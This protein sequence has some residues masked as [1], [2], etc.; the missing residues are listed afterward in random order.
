MKKYKQ[1]S[2]EERVTIKICLW[3]KM[4]INEIARNM[5]RSPSTISR[6]IKRGITIAGTYFADSTERQIRQKKLN[7]KRKRKMDNHLIQQYVLEKLKDKQSPHVIQVDIEKDIG[8]SIGKDAIYDFIY[9][10]RQEWTKYLKRKHKWRKKMKKNKSKKTIIPNRINIS[11]RPLETTERLEFGHFEADTIFS[12]KGSKSALL[13]IVD[14]LTRKI[15]IKKLARKTSSLTSSSIVIALKSEYKSSQ[16][17]S[18]TYDNGCEFAGHEKVNK[19][20]NC[21]SYFCNPYHS[22]EKGTVENINWFIRWHFPKGT[23]FDNITDEEIQYVEDWFNNRSMKT[24]NR[25]SP[26]QMYKKLM[27]VAV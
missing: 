3:K 22:W 20:L 1:L 11:E 25:L 19:K 10:Y 26:N 8:L 5:G 6:E 17:H 7:D 2:Y 16:I 13:V 9:R 24:L 12:C 23:N 18:I 27:G 15:K 21:K 14:R 4:S